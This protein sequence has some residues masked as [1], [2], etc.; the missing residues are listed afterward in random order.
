MFHFLC[1]SYRWGLRETR[2]REAILP[3]IR[4]PL[5]LHSRVGVES[6]RFALA[7]SHYG[8]ALVLFA[9]RLLRLRLTD[10]KIGHYNVAAMHER[11]LT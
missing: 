7:L 5:M 8:T 2:I 4:F 11:F 1:P 10:L 6:F 9:S 3:F